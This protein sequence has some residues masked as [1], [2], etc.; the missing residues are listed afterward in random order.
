MI[1][2][3]RQTT[4]PHD[5]KLTRRKFLVSTAAVAGVFSIVPRSVLGGNGNI[6]PSERVNLAFIGTGGQGLVNIKA[7]IGESDTQIVALCDVNEWAD[8]SPFYFGGVAGR[9]P[10]L[11]FVNNHY[12][13]KN[14]VGAYDG[15][16]EYI[17]FRKMLE[18]E[19]DIDA[20]VVSTCDHVHAAATMAAIKKGKH[21]Y[22]EKPLTH[23]I[24][25]ARTVTEAARA[26]G[27]ATQ[28][29]NQGHSGEG[30]RL[31]C[32]W[33]ADGAIGPVR[34]VHAW[35]A[36]GS[37]WTH[38]I[39][40]PQK[41]P[42]VPST[43]N[44]DL[45]LG[46]APLRPYHPEYVPYTWRTWWDF[47]TGAIGNMAPHN[48][49]PAFAALKLS[50]PTA[51][52]A[53]S[54]RMSSQTS[55]IASIVR[56]EFPARENMPPV[57]MTWYAGGLKPPRP[58]ELEAERRLGAEGIFLVG[59]KGKILCGGWAGTPRIIPESRMKTYVRPPRTLPRTPGVYRE[60]V[61][62][63][64]GGEPAS[65]N[66][67]VAGSM[68]E[69]ILLGN[70]AL[71]ANL[72]DPDLSNWH[73]DSRRLLWDGPNMQVTSWPPANQYVRRPRREGWEL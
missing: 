16:A 12:A 23:D 33:I 14:G 9:K 25:E 20:V 15:C 39:A 71:Q 21:V 53:S 7:L 57:N 50:H 5:D 22:C 49:D 69:V 32:E 68:I 60:W 73:E 70:V 63:C 67:D 30:L 42:A 24:Y 51:V 55:P 29:G 41:T 10:S 56:Y 6:P 18:K 45:W 54:A 44:W 47:G 58:P 13:Q 8:Y 2:E 65:S 28:M 64:K 38:R 59:D 46:P 31:T 26:A 34:E 19:S 66:F 52:E 11:E 62:A 37:D 43:L 3:P 1:S 40:P 4:L 61:N 48:M 36:T 35:T 27:V 72:R 17:D